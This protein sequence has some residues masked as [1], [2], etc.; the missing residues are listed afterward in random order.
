MILYIETN[1]VLELVFHQSQAK[2]ADKIL[3]LAEDGKIDLAIPSFSLQEPYWTLDHR[4]KLRRKSYK[5][6]KDSLM[7]YAQIVPSQRI[8]PILDPI[9]NDIEQMESDQAERFA[10]TVNRL[11]EVA[12]PLDISGEVLKQALAAPERINQSYFDNAIFFSILENLQIRN[13]DELKCFTSLNWRDFEHRHIREV[14]ERFNCT[15]IPNFKDCWNFLNT[16]R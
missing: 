9:L 12:I 5:A 6:L 16:N 10:I 11:L 14:L 1:F 8:S 15:Y 4:K 2:Y 3:S 13:I 7:T